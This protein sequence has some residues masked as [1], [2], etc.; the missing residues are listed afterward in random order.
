MTTSVIGARLRDVLP[1]SRIDT[2]AITLTVNAR[3]GGFY[4]YRPQAVVRVTNEHEVCA[5]LAV[6]R[7]MRLPVTFRAG[8]TSPPA[9][10]SARGS[11]WTS[12]TRSPGSKSSTRARGSKPSQARPLRW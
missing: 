4:E 10:R 11:S 9:K 1:E 8:G 6:A 7:E 12:A 3:D 5:L 2:T